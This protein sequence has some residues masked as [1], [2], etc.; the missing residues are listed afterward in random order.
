MQGGS[1]LFSRNRLVRVVVLRLDLIQ[2]A[3]DTK[4][5][6]RLVVASER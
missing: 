3:L 4:C 1:M 2:A 5:A 6:D